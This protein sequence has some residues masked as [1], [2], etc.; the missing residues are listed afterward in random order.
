MFVKRSV[1]VGKETE[2]RISLDQ[3]QQQALLL[4]IRE[5]GQRR[6]ET[7]Q[8]HRRKLRITGLDR[9]ME[10]LSSQSGLD[11]SVVEAAPSG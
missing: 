4:M 9:R 10:L 2:P 7:R 3:E 6:R 1:G 5:L 11:F 8:A